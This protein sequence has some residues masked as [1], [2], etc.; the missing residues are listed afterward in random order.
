[1]QF[2]DQKLF[3]LCELFQHVEGL[4]LLVRGMDE[5]RHVLHVGQKALQAHEADELYDF[6]PDKTQ[7]ICQVVHPGFC[8]LVSC[9]CPAPAAE[10]G[11]HDSAGIEALGIGKE[12]RFVQAF[13]SLK[14]VLHQYACG[15]DPG[16]VFASLKVACV[17]QRSQG[18]AH[19][20]LH[21]G[22]A[23]VPACLPGDFQ[24]RAP[25]TRAAPCERPYGSPDLLDFANA[26]LCLIEQKEVLVEIRIVVEH[27]AVC[28][29]GRVAAGTASFLHVV[30]QGAG[31]VI[32]NDKAH[33]L[34][35]YAHAKGRGRNN[36]PDLAPHEGFLVFD[37]VCRVHFAVEGQ[38]SKAVACQFLCQLFCLAGSGNIDNGWAVPCG[39][40][41]AQGGVLFLVRFPEEHLVVQVFAGL[42]RG[43]DLQIQI[44]R[45]P[46]ILADVAYDLLLGSGRE[47][48]NGD[49]FFPE[50]LCLLQLPDEVSYVLIVHSEVLPPGGKAVGL[51]D[52][53]ADNVSSEQQPFYSA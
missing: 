21:I 45:L 15:I 3:Q 11:G 14:H 23:V 6:F 30:F 18:G 9:S 35:V 13:S 32:V 50:P 19:P 16:H 37:L 29:Q 26:E 25:Y 24:W 41:I 8:F 12:S 51:V 28:L 4:V 1:M 22:I 44:Q 52:N 20:C 34:L 46:E 2:A 38:G 31:N 49:G 40:K 47:A 43:K 48:G 36:A 10:E 17:F 53:K 7:A 39:H 33:V 27:I 5:G 42:G